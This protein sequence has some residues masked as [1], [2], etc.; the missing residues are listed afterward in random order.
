[1]SWWD[2]RDKYL[3]QAMGRESFDFNDKL[4]D[5]EWADF[6]EQWADVFAERASE[7]AYELWLD[8]LNYKPDIRQ[9]IEEEDE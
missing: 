9:R 3:W 6:V 4:T 8:W 7:L 2:E 5:K 1:M